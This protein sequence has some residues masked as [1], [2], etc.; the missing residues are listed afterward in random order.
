MRFA[1]ALLVLT[2]AGNPV[3]G[4]ASQKKD[5]TTDKHTAKFGDLV[6]TATNIASTESAAHE[7]DHHVVAVFVSVKNSGKGAVCAYL[8][9]TLQ[10]TFGL[11][12]EGS[13][14][15][16]QFPE[17]PRMKQMLPGEEA[18]GSYAFYVKDRVE[19]IALVLKL[20]NRT[21]RCGP[22]SDRPWHDVF[23]PDEIRLD[24]HDLPAPERRAQQQ[25]TPPQQK[26][27]YTVAEHNAYKAAD[28][29]QNPQAK[30]KLLDDFVKQYPNS[31]LLPSIYFDYA[32]AYY[33][34]NDFPTAIRYCDRA[35]TSGDTIDSDIQT[36]VRLIRADAEQKMQQSDRTRITR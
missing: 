6:V 35:L 25:F 16:Q 7:G 26:P 2:I 19:P 28:A 17:A 9:A 14:G 4:A 5:K 34:L 32:Q 30:I 18:E 24:V 1:T 20:S 12:F 13:G 29:E 3:P 21:I 10:A 36:R 11:E 8:G 27:A 23:V 15:A 22:P 33:Q 31:V